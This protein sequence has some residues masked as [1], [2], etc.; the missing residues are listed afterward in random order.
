VGEEAAE[1]PAVTPVVAPV[2]GPTEQ[3]R[4]QVRGVGSLAQHVRVM[5]LLQTAEGVQAAS[6]RALR[7]DVV[8]VDV[9]ARGGSAQVERLVQ[10]GFL[11]PDAAT[12]AGAAGPWSFADAR[13]RYRVRQ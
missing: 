13:L 8:L 11:E 12:P 4:V 3:V 1:V 9:T 6:P 2:S 7:G 5:R 10:L